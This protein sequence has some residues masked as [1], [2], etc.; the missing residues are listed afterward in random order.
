MKRNLK[1]SAN[2]LISEVHYN[3]LKV[4]GTVGRQFAP[5]GSIQRRFQNG[6]NNLLIAVSY[7]TLKKRAA[8]LKRQFA[9]QVLYREDLKMVQII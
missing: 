5:P 1:G 2:C 9:P 8:C 4:V 7:N 6:A 3:I